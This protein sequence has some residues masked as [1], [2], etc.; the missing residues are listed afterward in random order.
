MRNS[1]LVE[2]V[3]EFKNKRVV[4]VGDLALDGYLYGRVERINPERPGFP[5]FRVESKEYRL[6]CAG[7]VAINV[8]ALGVD[9]TLFGII[10]ED[11]HG[12][13]FKELCKEKGI[14]TNLQAE[15]ETILKQRRIELSHND[16]LGRDDYGESDLKSISIDLQEIFI[17][18]IEKNGPDA[19][20]LSDYDKGMFRGEFGLNVVNWARNEGI[21]TVVD[22][23]P[24]NIRRFGQPTLTCP[25]IYEAREV[26]GYTDYED[27]AEALKKKTGSKYV[28]IT[29]GSDGMIAYNGGFHTIPTQARG[30]VDVTGAGDTVASVLALSI[31]SGA[32]YIRAAQIANYAAGL[33]VEKPGTATITSKELIEGIRN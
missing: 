24:A 14:D 12:N 19:I 2:I 5:L 7:N 9:T 15:G 23:K 13:T 16:Y 1:E 22:P 17:S 26:T 33:V 29:C 32:D 28:V 30:V 8:A 6:G 27:V 4:V 25:N 18:E 10:G 21:I 31:T 11:N 20:I 3:E